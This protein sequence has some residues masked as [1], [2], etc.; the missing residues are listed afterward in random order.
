MP[1]PLSLWLL[2]I[3]FSFASLKARLSIYSIGS[4]EDFFFGIAYSSSQHMFYHVIKYLT[5]VQKN[6]PYIA[7]AL[8]YYR[9]LFYNHQGIKHLFTYLRRQYQTTLILQHHSFRICHRHKICIINHLRQDQCPRHLHRL[10]YT[11][12]SL[13]RYTHQGQPHL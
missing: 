9:N 2:P 7:N 4:L 10:H 5:I 3:I 11:L 13:S 1:I 6:Q 12:L 8:I